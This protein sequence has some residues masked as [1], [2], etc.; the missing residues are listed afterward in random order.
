MLT[1]LVCCG[2]PEKGSSCRFVEKI[3]AWQPLILPLEPS[4]TLSAERLRGCCQ[5][6][7]QDARTSSCHFHL[8]LLSLPPI[9]KLTLLPR[10]S[11]QIPQIYNVSVWFSGLV[12]VSFKWDNCLN[13][14]L[15][16]MSSSGGNNSLQLCLKENLYKNYSP[17]TLLPFP[18]TSPL[19]FHDPLA[20]FCHMFTVN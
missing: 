14:Y 20:S 15:S 11:S 3:K 5:V 9:Q 16:H 10:K 4:W 8:C 7:C 1:L 19:P 17:S 18:P 2:E 12:F 13:F 6:S